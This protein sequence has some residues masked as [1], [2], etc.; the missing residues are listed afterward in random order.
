MVA[1]G[2][3]PGS[4]SKRACWASCSEGTIAPDCTG[5]VANRL[6]EYQLVGYDSQSGARVA[7]RVREA[8]HA[9]RLSEPMKECKEDA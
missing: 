4:R 2:V 1:S 7:I 3:P 5:A 9:A 8:L 6:Y